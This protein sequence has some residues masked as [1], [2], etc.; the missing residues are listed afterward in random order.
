MEIPFARWY[1]GIATRRSRRQYD[2]SRPL[3]PDILA[4][5]QKI[6][7]EFRPF[8]DARVEL[9]TDS[10]GKIFKFVAGSYGVI[11]DPPAAFVFIGNV[12]NRHVQEEVGYTG[13]GIILESHALGLSTCWVAGFF[14]PGAAAELAKIKGNEKVLAASPVGFT[15]E[16]MSLIDNIMA[17][18]GRHSLR[19][20][21]SELVNKGIP[22]NEWPAW[23]KP[24][25]EAARQSPS[26]TNRQPWRFQVEAKA[27]LVST[28]S[29]EV[30]FKVS[31]RL[32]CGMAMLHLE[33]AALNQ[34]IKGQW[35]LL[36]APQVARFKF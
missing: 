19:K 22:E 23:V 26:A 36:E 35:E 24:A 20:P 32:D 4:N 10:P 8:P 28:D 11:K 9:V 3:P 1:P 12:N 6:C 7:T 25:L 27:I 33:V 30:D 16:S 15:K 29:G 31:K 13:E 2:A 17:S 34:G 14:K 5:L 21:L 18:F